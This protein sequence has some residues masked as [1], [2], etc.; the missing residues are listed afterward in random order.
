MALK[1]LDSV[2]TLEMNTQEQSTDTSIVRAK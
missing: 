2:R 1:K